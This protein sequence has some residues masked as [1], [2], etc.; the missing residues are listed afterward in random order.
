ME[1]SVPRRIAELEEQLA[2]LRARLPKHSAPPA[3]WV[4][5]EDVETELARLRQAPD[6]LQESQT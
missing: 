5:I 2:N 3:M 6:E 1:R 4:E